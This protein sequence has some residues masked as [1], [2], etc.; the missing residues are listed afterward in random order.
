[1]R[2]VIIESAERLLMKNGVERT[3]LA[4]ISNEAKISKGT[5]Y[6]YYKSKNDLIFDI[7]EKHLEKATKE[8]LDFINSIEVLD[9]DKLLN[10]LYEKVIKDEMRNKLHIYLIQEAI[11]NNEN[12]KERFIN[13]YNLWREDIKKAIKS[14]IKK[15]DEDYDT[16]SLIILS[17][18]D[19]LIIQHILGIENIQLEKFAEYFF[20]KVGE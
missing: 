5:L 15:S 10:L 11:R 8:I 19:G 20:N 4:D 17:C 16:I 9:T 6:Y 7:T 12:I 13:S 14:N 1:M 18:L 2:T 3:T